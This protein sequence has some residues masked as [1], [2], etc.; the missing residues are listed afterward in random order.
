MG[1]EDLLR[2]VG[3][4]TRCADSADLTPSLPT[5][6]RSLIQASSSVLRCTGERIDFIFARTE[7]T[8]AVDGSVSHYYDYVLALGQLAFKVRGPTGRRAED[9]Y[10]DNECR[11]DLADRNQGALAG[12]RDD[13]ST[14]TAL[15]TLPGTTT[16]GR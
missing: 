9:A 11:R 4:T 7:I 2:P 10:N 16:R 14:T 6:T 1:R 15:L 5:R 12:R 13:C 3:T 8:S